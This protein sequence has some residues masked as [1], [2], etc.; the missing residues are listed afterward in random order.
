MNI[1]SLFRKQLTGF[2]DTIN[3][4]TSD[5]L[6]SIVFLVSWF[7]LLGIF[8]AQHG[9]L[10]GLV[11]TVITSTVVCILSYNIYALLFKK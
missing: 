9:F 7:V 11:K 3:G 10:I 2:L 4:A 8:I 5:Q 1:K 6:T